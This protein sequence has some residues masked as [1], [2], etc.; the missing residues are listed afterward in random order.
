MKIE[1]NAQQQTALKAFLDT[2]E[3]SEQ[4]SATEYVVDLY[5]LEPPIS[6]DLTL[7][8]KGFFVDGAAV[9]CFDEELD[10]WY[11]GERIEQAEAV[12]QALEKAGA[13]GQ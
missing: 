12:F 2:F 11:V 13:F 1:L 7:N 4:L 6:L 9:L 3:D 5:D 8:K 10:G